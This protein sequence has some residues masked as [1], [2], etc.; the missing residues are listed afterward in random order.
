MLIM[1]TV[2]VIFLSNSELKR[3]LQW[4]FPAVLGRWREINV[5]LPCI[6]VH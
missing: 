4:I 3:E 1:K 5:A 6:F 2:M